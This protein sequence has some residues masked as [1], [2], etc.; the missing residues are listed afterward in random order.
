[1]SKAVK[2]DIMAHGAGQGAGRQPGRRDTGEPAST[3]RGGLPVRGSP[4]PGV[5][6]HEPLQQGHL[7]AGPELHGHGVPE[8][9]GFLPAEILPAGERPQFRQPQQ[10]PRLPPHP[11]LPAR[12]G[13]PGTLPLYYYFL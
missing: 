12:H 1:M 5:L 11:A 2:S 3:G 13:L 7:V 4:L 9:R 6:G 10:V 8:L